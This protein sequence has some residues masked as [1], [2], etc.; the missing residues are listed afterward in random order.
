MSH[1]VKNT[2]SYINFMSDCIMLLEIA[3]SHSIKC[4]IKIQLQS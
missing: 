1:N 4:I 3:R 2:Q